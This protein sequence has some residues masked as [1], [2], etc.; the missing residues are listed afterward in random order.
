MGKDRKLIIKEKLGAEKEKIRGMTK[1]KAAAYIWTYY[2]I[3]IIAVFV[4]V[5]LVIYFIHAFLNRTED[6]LLHVTFVNCYDD[7]SEKSQFYKDFFEYAGYQKTG[8][9]VFDSNVFFGLSKDRDYS[10]TYFQKTVAYLEA[11]TTHAVVCQEMNLNGLA[12]G[13]RVLSLEDER[14]EKIREKYKDRIVNFTTEEGE[15][16]PVGIDISDSRFIE[17]MNSYEE[18]CFVCVS[19]YI[20]QTDRVE[21]F[22]D[23]LLE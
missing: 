11:G 8:E 1:E 18:G 4:F 17:E 5:F 22:L 9:V 23:Y 6:A 15:V 10:N 16:V 3:P 14:A 21:E 2:K 12:K 13:K 20:D 19:A 7:V